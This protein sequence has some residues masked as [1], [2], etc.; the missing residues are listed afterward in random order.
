MKGFKLILP[1]QQE[2][3]CDFVQGFELK[4]SKFQKTNLLEDLTISY[5]F[6]SDNEECEMDLKSSFYYDNYESNQMVLKFAIMVILTGLH[7]LLL[8]IYMIKKFNDHERLCKNQSVVF[9]VGMG[10]LNSLF[11]FMNILCSTI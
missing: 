1:Q 6:S 9:W 11:C 10:M 2:M 7:D 4:D 5:H 8:I 3:T